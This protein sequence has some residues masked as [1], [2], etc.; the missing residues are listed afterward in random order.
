MWYLTEFSICSTV[1]TLES[2]WLIKED[3]TE[4][5]AFLAKRM[6]AMPSF[7]S[8]RK[9]RHGVVKNKEN[10]DIWIKG[11]HVCV[12][13]CSSFLT[14]LW[15]GFPVECGGRYGVN[16]LQANR[17]KVLSA[18]HLNLQSVVRRTKIYRKF[19]CFLQGTICILK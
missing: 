8:L 2:C 7:W 4:N 5:S 1:L 9:K 6:S 19:W 18:A 10:V 17:P 13:L 11:I 12:D 15:Y 14:N 3:K 16:K